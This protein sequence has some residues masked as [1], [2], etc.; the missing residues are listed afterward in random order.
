LSHPSQ[1]LVSLL[2]LPIAGGEMS[3]IPA[4]KIELNRIIARAEIPYVPPP[5]NHA[6]DGEEVC[7]FAWGDGT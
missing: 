6:Y 3:A 1:S 7:C 5:A 2:E 4:K